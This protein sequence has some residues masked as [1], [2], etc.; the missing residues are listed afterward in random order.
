[1]ATLT[2]GFFSLPFD[3][4][5]ETLRYLSPADITRLGA[6]SLETRR[7]INHLHSSLDLQTSA[8]THRFTT[9]LD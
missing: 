6:V 3:I 2:S 5:F 4:I 9:N 7:V 1:M 8:R